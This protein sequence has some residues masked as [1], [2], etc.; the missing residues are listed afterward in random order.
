MD[1]AVMG[2]PRQTPVSS[3][4]SDRSARQ[5]PVGAA[6]MGLLIKTPVSSAGRFGKGR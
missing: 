2:P 5:E 4:R 6:L 3:D 1:A